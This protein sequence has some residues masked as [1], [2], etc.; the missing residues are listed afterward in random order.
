VRLPDPLER[1]TVPAW[2]WL[3]LAFDKRRSA[4]LELCRRAA[5]GHPEALPVPV[6]KIGGS[7]RVPT[8]SLRRVLGLDPEDGD[9]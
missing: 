8:A 5:N 2:P 4:V 7:Y 1:P 9:A 6:F 3:G